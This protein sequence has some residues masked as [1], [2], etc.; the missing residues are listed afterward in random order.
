MLESFLDWNKRLG[1]VIPESSV[2]ML[3]ETGIGLS[4]STR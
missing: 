3:V 1:F 2:D 4:D